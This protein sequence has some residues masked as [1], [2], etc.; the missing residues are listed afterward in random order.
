[1]NIKNLID[2]NKNIKFFET[3][4]I[5]LNKIPAAFLYLNPTKSSLFSKP[6]KKTKQN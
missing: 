1:M 3:S 4:V 2:F 6:K 5:Y